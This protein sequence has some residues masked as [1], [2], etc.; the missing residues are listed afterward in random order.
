M[1]PYTNAQDVDRKQDITDVHRDILEVLVIL[2][3]KILY[4]YQVL[5]ITKSLIKLT[6]PQVNISNIDTSLRF[7]STHTYYPDIV[8]FLH[9]RHHPT[10]NTEQLNLE[11]LTQKNQVNPAIKNFIT[12][13]LATPRSC[14]SNRCAFLDSVPN[15][16]L[17]QLLTCTRINIVT[18]LS[19]ALS[20]NTITLV[21]NLLY[22]LLL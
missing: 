20:N 14:Q 8:P 22:V 10:T 6:I 16:N 5:A 11:P 21:K 13:S 15:D 17:I 19:D 18:K 7:P 3:T 2:L 9:C 12:L 1:C 4:A